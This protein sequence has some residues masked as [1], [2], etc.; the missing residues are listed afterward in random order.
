MKFYGNSVKFPRKFPFLSF[1]S[2]IP[3]HITLTVIFLI[4]KFSPESFSVI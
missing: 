1:T 4:L 3:I 2:N